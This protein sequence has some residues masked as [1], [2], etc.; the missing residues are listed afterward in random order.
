MAEPRSPCAIVRD[1]AEA[2]NRGERFLGV[3]VLDHRGCFM[4]DGLVKTRSS[5]SC[6]IDNVCRNSMA[7]E[8]RLPAFTPVR[9]GFQARARMCGTMNHDDRRHSP[10]LLRRDL[11]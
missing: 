11:E 8:I 5:P 3:A 1:S 6:L 2:G 9:R 10:S 4:N 7:H